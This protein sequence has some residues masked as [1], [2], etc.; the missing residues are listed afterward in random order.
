MRVE[1]DTFVIFGITLDIL[2]DDKPDNNAKSCVSG[3]SLNSFFQSLIVRKDH[4]MAKEAMLNCY[5]APLFYLDK[6]FAGR[7]Y[8]KL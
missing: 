6:H 4:P 3:C 7:P 1:L 5:G 2:F 8:G